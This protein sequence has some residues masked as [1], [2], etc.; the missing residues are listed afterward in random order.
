MALKEVM[1]EVKKLSN[2]DMHRLI[3]F[4]TQSVTPLSPQEPLFEEIRDLKHKGGYTCPHCQSNLSVR[5]GKYVVK[6]GLKKMN[7]QRYRCKDC[8]KTFTDVTNTPLYRTHKPDKWFDFVR[9]MI[10]GETLRK[11]A[12]KLDVHHVTLFYWRHKLLSALE[13]MDFEKFAGIVEMDETYFLYSE[14]GKRGIQGRKPRKRG[15]SSQFRGIS[16]EQICVLVARDR[17]KSTYSRVIGEGRILKT[18]LH[19]AIGAKLTSENVLCT[20]AWRAFKTYAKEKGMNHYA[21]KSDGKERVKGLYH[22][23]NVNSYHGRLKNWMKRFNGV[24]TKYLDHYLSWFQFLDAIKHRNNSGTVSKMMI[25]SCL[26]PVT[27][28][29][30]ALRTYQYKI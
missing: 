20:D 26:F 8:L 4:L 9:C 2:K 21:F 3:Q 18:R 14:K 12:E 22:I 17:Q 7:R 1:Q 5:F 15:G 30:Q 23:Q 11:A 10:D 28:T 19:Q 29:Y 6:V 13:Q 27:E 25:E 16:H 24:A